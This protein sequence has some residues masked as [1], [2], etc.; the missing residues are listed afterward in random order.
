M[1][2]LAY[3]ASL[4]YAKERPQVRKLSSDGRKN[5]DSDPVLIIEHADVRRMLLFQKAVVEGSLSLMLEAS[6][7][8]DKNL[9]GE[10]KENNHLLL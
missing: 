6:M 4:Q 9:A 1:L 8:M 5:P 3:Y 2:L 10:D 7:F